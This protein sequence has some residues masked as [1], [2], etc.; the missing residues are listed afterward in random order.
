LNAGLANQDALSL[1]TWIAS[2]LYTQTGRQHRQHPT[3]IACVLASYDVDAHCWIKV[4][5]SMV[6]AG[7]PQRESK[8]KGYWFMIRFF[9]PDR[10]QQDIGSKTN[11]QG[12]FKEEGLSST[13]L[14]IA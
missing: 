9:V 6:P 7:N 12:E 13:H 3:I 5:T 2:Q 14:E 1:H 4:E 8:V 10:S 11:G